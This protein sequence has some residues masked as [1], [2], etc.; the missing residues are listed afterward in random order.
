VNE[1]RRTNPELEKI[2]PLFAIQAAKGGYEAITK[3][4]GRKDRSGAASGWMV[5]VV[6][7]VVSTRLRQGEKADRQEHGGDRS[8]RSIHKGP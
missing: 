3:G 2:Q 8:Q 6:D 5:W 1:G 7:G 4:R